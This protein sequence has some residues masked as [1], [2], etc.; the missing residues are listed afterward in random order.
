MTK[1]NGVIV[2]SNS[3]RPLDD[4]DGLP[5]IEDLLEVYRKEIR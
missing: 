5:K 3:K 2:D 4:S 1:N